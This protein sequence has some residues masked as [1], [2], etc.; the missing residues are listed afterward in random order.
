MYVGCFVDREMKMISCMTGFSENLQKIFKEGLG[1]KRVRQV[2]L[3][4][5][6]FSCL[7]CGVISSFVIQFA[8]HSF[9]SLVF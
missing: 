8:G 7:N 6:R 5:C 1:V 2:M 3:E 9:L 4:C